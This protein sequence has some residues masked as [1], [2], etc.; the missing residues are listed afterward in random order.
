MSSPKTRTF[1]EPPPTLEQV[2]ASVRRLY[3]VANHMGQRRLGNLAGV[4]GLVGGPV[5]ER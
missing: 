1:H 5:P 2:R 3:L 4:I